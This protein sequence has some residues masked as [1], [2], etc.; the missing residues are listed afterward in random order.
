MNPKITTTTL[1]ERTKTNSKIRI[2]RDYRS[3]PGQTYF[4]G[5]LNDFR[6][7][8]HALS[9]KEVEEIAKGLVLHYKLDEP[10]PNLLKLGNVE[11]TGDSQSAHILYYYYDFSG[12]LPVGTYTLSFDA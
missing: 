11:Q 6:I 9:A 12:N 4:T 8:D 10:N 5:C 7:Y 2:G 1:A 3:S